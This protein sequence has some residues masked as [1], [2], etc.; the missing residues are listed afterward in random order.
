MPGQCMSV[1]KSDLQKLEGKNISAIC[2]NGYHNQK[3]NH[4]AH[5][6]SHVIGLG[7]GYTC[8]VHTGRGTVGANLRVQEIF[9]KCVQ[10]GKWTNRGSVDPCLVFVLSAAEVDIANKKMTN[11]PRKHIGIYVAGTIWHYSN[12]MDKVVTQT[13][14]EFA[15]HYP[16]LPGAALFFGSFPLLQ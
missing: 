8:K 16:K 2:G 6:V 14:D 7:F 4:C 11:V 10:V 12:S 3:D 9:S 5:F 1:S 13:P 15:K